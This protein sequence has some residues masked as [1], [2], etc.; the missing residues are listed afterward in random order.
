MLK[1]ICKMNCASCFALPVC[2]VGALLEQQGSICVDTGK[3]I[4]CGSCRTACI[5]F[6][7]DHALKRNVA[8]KM[9]HPMP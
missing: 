3:C 7:R 6:G 4:N 8:M 1:A 5:T 9:K 2:A